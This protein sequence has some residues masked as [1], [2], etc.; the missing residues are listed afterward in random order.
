MQLGAKRRSAILAAAL[1]IAAP[2]FFSQAHLVQTDLPATAFGGRSPGHCSSPTRGAAAFA[3]FSVL[4]V[5]TKEST[6]YLCLPAAVLL[7]GRALA[8]GA[9]VFS[10]ATLRRLVPSLA[11]GLARFI[12]W[13][14]VH[15]SLTGHFVHPDHQEVFDRL[16]WIAALAHT[17]VEGGHIA[18]VAAA[19]LCCAPALRRI[20]RDPRA[21]RGLARPHDLEISATVFVVVLLPLAFPGGLVRYMLPTLSCARRARGARGRASYWMRAAASAPCRL[22]ACLL[23][24]WWGPSFHHNTPYEREGNLGYRAVLD[25]HVG[26]RASCRGARTARHIGRISHELDRDRAADRRLFADAAAAHPPKEARACA[27]ADLLC[28]RRPPTGSTRC[29]SP[30]ARAARCRCST[31]GGMCAASGA[32]PPTWARTDVFVRLYRVDCARR[33]S[34]GGVFHERDE[35]RDRDERRERRQLHASPSAATLPND[36][37]ARLRPRSREL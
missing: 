24:G 10:F 3:V 6:Y 30:C 27:E 15:R 33:C 9:A 17:Y 20:A 36:C 19:L 25:V 16:S 21:T 26:R 4:A 34:R 37:S 1:C 8:E 13:L 32:G 22:L 14:F 5:W 18:L 2:A 7:L 11:P 29:E 12:A 31:P 35:R 28:S 23:S